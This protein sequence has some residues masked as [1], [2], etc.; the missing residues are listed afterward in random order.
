MQRQARLQAMK[1]VCGIF[2]KPEPEFRD[3]AGHIFRRR[4][5]LYV[6]GNA[7]GLSQCRAHHRPAVL[8][9]GGAACGGYVLA[10]NKNGTTGWFMIGNRGFQPGE[11]CKVLIIIV[12]AKVL[13]D[14]TE[15]NDDGLQTMRDIFSGAVARDDSCRAG[16]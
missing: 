5:F 9:D 14:K 1:N 16:S 3:V 7:G 10:A 4:P 8:G 13:S 15:G 11:V 6:F 12:L 2:C